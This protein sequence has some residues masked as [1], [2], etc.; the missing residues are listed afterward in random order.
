[1]SRDH[2]P[3]GAAG[4]DK[5]LKRQTGRL[6]ALRCRLVES[7][8]QKKVESPASKV[9]AC[10]GHGPRQ[11]PREHRDIGRLQ[12][13][14]KGMPDC[15]LIATEAGIYGWEFGSVALFGSFGWLVDVLAPPPVPGA[16]DAGVGFPSQVRPVRRAAMHAGTD[17]SALCF[18]ARVPSRLDKTAHAKS[19]SDWTVDRQAQQGLR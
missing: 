19:P 3:N 8:V 18:L 13:R 2:E 10:A 16:P 17:A 4:Y 15:G 7:W 12:G 11:E 6:A 14:P 1:M 5:M 9:C